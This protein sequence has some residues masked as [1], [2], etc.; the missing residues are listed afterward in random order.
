MLP[1]L[2]L[3]PLAYRLPSRHLL[4]L[5]TFL[6]GVPHPD[7]ITQ[8]WVFGMGQHDDMAPTAPIERDDQAALADAEGAGH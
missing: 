6:I 1:T 3:I 4:F 8:L 7:F 5:N 2:L